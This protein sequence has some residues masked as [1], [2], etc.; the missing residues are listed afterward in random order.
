MSTPPTIFKIRTPYKKCRHCGHRVPNPYDTV[1]PECHVPAADA[2][3]AMSKAAEWMAAIL[4]VVVVLLALPK[5]HQLLLE[6][7]DRFG[8]H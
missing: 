4:C 2:N 3:Q 7:A 1:C 8:H 5:M 6:L